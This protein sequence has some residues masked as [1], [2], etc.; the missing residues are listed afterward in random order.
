MVDELADNGYSLQLTASK[1]EDV[2]PIYNAIASRR[3]LT[4]AGAVLALLALSW[5]TRKTALVRLLK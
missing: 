1:W 3:T 2:E 5:R 4:L